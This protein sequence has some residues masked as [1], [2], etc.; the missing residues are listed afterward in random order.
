MET[1]KNTMDNVTDDN[2]LKHKVI[3]YL[4]LT[5]TISNSRLTS[6]RQVGGIRPILSQL[7]DDFLIVKIKNNAAWIYQKDTSPLRTRLNTVGEINEAICTG[8][9]RTTRSWYVWEKIQ[10]AIQ[11]LYAEYP[12]LFWDGTIPT[13][14]R[15]S[16]YVRPSIST[17]QYVLVGRK[18][19]VLLEGLY[20]L[21]TGIGSHVQFMI[22]EEIRQGA[23]K[24]KFRTHILFRSGKRVPL[25]TVGI[26]D[27][28]DVQK[29]I[30][31]V[32]V[33]N[34]TDLF[35]ELLDQKVL[36]VHDEKLC[37]QFEKRKL[38]EQK[39]DSMWLETIDLSFQEY[40][41]MCRAYA[42]D[43]RVLAAIGV[44][45]GKDQ[46]KGGSEETINVRSASCK[47]RCLKG[48]NLDMQKQLDKK[49]EELEEIMQQHLCA[50][51]LDNPRCIISSPCNHFIG[52]E[53]CSLKIKATTN[54]CPICRANIGST[55]KVFL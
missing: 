44:G 37:Q 32:D 35:D 49:A 24:D 39:R 42:Y 13:L 17:G 47:I 54:Q 29:L 43:L 11:A 16:Y 8:T 25:A 5:R 40:I 4:E 6:G 22:K 52:C 33:E 12:Y 30:R 26:R 48:E 15:I 18:V 31:N 10:L 14:D 9:L 2:D 7:P 46:Q 34:L 51:C 38:K 55:M 19:I 41:E 3:K 45:D 36:D 50:I 20:T 21:D 23:T 27:S 53:K 1:F 28:S